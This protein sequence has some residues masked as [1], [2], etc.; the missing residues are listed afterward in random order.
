ML[1]A[2]AN[3]TF[4]WVTLLLLVIILLCVLVPFGRRL[5]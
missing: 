3:E 5:P 4:Q 2:M 1:I